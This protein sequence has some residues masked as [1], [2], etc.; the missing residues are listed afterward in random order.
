MKRWELLAFLLVTSL[1]LSAA[2]KPRVFI[3]DSKSWEIAGGFGATR[4]AAAGSL[5]GGARPQ[6]AE[7][8]KTFGEHC[9]EITVTM[10]QEKADYIVLLDHEGGK[11]LAL[12]DNK[13][14]VFNK[15]GDMIFSTSTRTLGNAVKDACEAIKKNLAVSGSPALSS[16]P[17]TPAASAPESP[18]SNGEKGYIDCGTS[19]PDVKL[20]PPGND[21]HPLANLQ[22]GE[23]VTVL[24][25][26]EG[27]ALVRTKDR[28]EGYV[29]RWNVSK[30][31]RVAK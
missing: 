9:P 2:D 6:T 7:I 23:E 26:Q 22:C 24:R 21:P 8:M 1:T 18:T 27:W 16:Q 28:Q 14:V 19:L 5:S 4:D 25:W 13:V 30:T 29:S 12:R 3:A 10:R 31:K 11:G 20:M 17:R 15:D